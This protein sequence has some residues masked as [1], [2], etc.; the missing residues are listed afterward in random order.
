MKTGEVIE[1]YEYTVNLLMNM[2]H[3]RHYPCVLTHN[4]DNR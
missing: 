1:S 2:I 4:P 3:S